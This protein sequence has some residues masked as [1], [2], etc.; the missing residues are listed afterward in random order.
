M[1]RREIRPTLP[2]DMSR[3]QQ[4]QNPPKFLLFDP[5]LLSDIRY[6]HSRV[7]GTFL[8]NISDLE[9]CGDSQADR[10]V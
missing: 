8:K 10:L 9:F 1:N 4:A 7:G 6:V 2:K 5:H 3:R